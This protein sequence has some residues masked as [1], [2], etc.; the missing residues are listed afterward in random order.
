MSAWCGCQLLAAAQNGT[1]S[2]GDTDASVTMAKVTDAARLHLQ[3]AEA[4]RN[5]AIEVL[6]AA[7]V[8]Q[9]S[10]AET[11]RD[12]AGGQAP[13]P[14]SGS[15]LAEMGGDQTAADH[16]SRLSRPS[17]LVGRSPDAGHRRRRL[18]R[19]QSVPLKRATYRPA[20]TSTPPA[21]ASNC[22]PGPN[23]PNAAP[24]VRSPARPPDA[25]YRTRPA[26]SLTS[27]MMGWTLR[28]RIESAHNWPGSVSGLIW[29][30]GIRTT[31]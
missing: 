18:D 2:A 5:A 7:E 28:N 4:D 22:A 20:S 21:S 8:K 9:I 15:P 6:R 17:G 30:Q 14:T 10:A 11:E 19:D 31:K 24:N 29:L 1:T 3:R 26:V 23:L 13:P 12:T 25:C 16:P 27:E